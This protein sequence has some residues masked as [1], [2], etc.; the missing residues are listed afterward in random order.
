MDA[1]IDSEAPRYCRG[2]V[3]QTPT[4]CRH[5]QSFYDYTKLTRSIHTTT[6]KPNRL[7]ATSNQAHFRLLAR[8]FLRGSMRRCCAVQS[9]GGMGACQLPL[10]DR[11]TSGGAPAATG[12]GAVVPGTEKCG[13][14]RQL[15]AFG[16]ICC[17]FFGVRAASKSFSGISTSGENGPKAAS[18]DLPNS[19]SRIR[20]RARAGSGAARARKALPA[21]PGEPGKGPTRAAAPELLRA[22]LGTPRGSVCARQCRAQTDPRRRIRGARTKPATETETTQDEGGARRVG[23]RLSRPGC[24]HGGGRGRS[25]GRT[26]CGCGRTAG[27]SRRGTPCRPRATARRSHRAF[28]VWIRRRVCGSELSGLISSQKRLHIRLR[29]QARSRRHDCGGRSREAGLSGSVPSSSS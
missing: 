7:A 13:S 21:R 15:S 23:G 25:Y 16:G 18:P 1:G 27:R 14:C 29:L 4:L 26:L 12:R 24:R 20:A 28:F 9:R 8:L 10:W 5:Y 22:A 3:A 2:W 11:L 17:M 19:A 6:P